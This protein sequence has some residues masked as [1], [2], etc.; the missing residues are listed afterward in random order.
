MT[1]SCDSLPVA[2]VFNH[3]FLGEACPIVGLD[4]PAGLRSPI[5]F[6]HSY[7]PA[8]ARRWLIPTGVD[9]IANFDRTR[10]DAHGSISKNSA[11]WFTRTQALSRHQAEHRNV[12][13]P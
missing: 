13:I 11:F 2:F 6:G 5:D 3:A 1:V 4:P 7:G 12:V 8:V 9:H 10:P